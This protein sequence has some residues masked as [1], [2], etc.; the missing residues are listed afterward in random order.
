MSKLSKEKQ[1]QILAVAVG[2]LTVAVAL[3]FVVIQG[4]TGSLTVTQRRT[5]EIRGKIDQATGFVRQAGV[6]AKRLEELKDA[7]GQKES[8]MVPDRD[9]YDWMLRTIRNFEQNRRS[10]GVRPLN[11]EQ[12]KMEEMG[13]IPNFPYKA[14]VFHA[15]GQGFFHEF[16]R[17]L[18][19]FE[20]KFRY[21]QVINLEISPGGATAPGGGLAPLT[22][23]DGELLQFKFDIVAPVKSTVVPAK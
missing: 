17:F 15:T 5:A 14:A 12:P 10:V 13:M 6:V 16:G 19:D 9:S 1:N 22:E 20:N 2:S 11:I 4:Q 23:A 21:Y 7:V 3:Y 18:A 8:T